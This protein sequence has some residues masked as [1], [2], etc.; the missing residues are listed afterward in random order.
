LILLVI[1]AGIDIDLST[2]KLIGTRG[3]LIAFFG[4]ILPIG[5]GM[6][7][8][9]ILGMT[10]IKEIIA[11]GAVFGPTS[12]G[13]A[14]NILRNGGILN[15]PVGQLIISAAVIDDMIALVVLSQLKALSGEITVAGILIPIVSAIAF[16]VFGGYIAVFILPPI[17]RNHILS[18]VDESNHARVE[19]GIMFFLVLALM[20][21]T[22]YAEASYL[23]G[24]F[25][26]GLTFCS[27]H[28]LHHAFVRQ[29][30]RVLQWLM[31]IFF[32]ASIGFQVPI[33]SFNDIEVIWQGL[34]YTLALIGKVAV[35][36]MVPNFSMDMRFTGK[37]LRDC[38]I[39]G[40]SM[41][42]EGEFAFVIAV[43]AVGDGLI[44][45]SLYAK[46]VLAV[47]LS[48][49][50]PPFL[51]RFTISYYNKKGEEAVE[52]AAKEE[53]NRRSIHKPN[54]ADIVHGVLQ[55]STIFLCIQTQSES[56]WGL[57][58]AIMGTMA[59][60]NLDV[61]DHRAWSPRGINTTLVN[62]IYARTMVSPHY[63]D[64]EDPSAAVEHATEVLMKDVDHALIRAINQPG[65]AKVKVQRWYPG[66]IQE[67]CEEV[68]E[69]SHKNVT[70]RL[71][72]EA[73]TKL[74][75]RQSLQTMATVQKSVAQILGEEE[76]PKPEIPSPETEPTPAV[77]KS[78]PRR[79]VRQKMRS[80]PVVGG[81]L[82]GET[83]EAKSGRDAST[84]LSDINK[85]SGG[86]ID[87]SFG[88]GKTG[89]PAEIT[90]KGEVYSIRIGQDTW[91][92]LQKGFHG[93]MVDN[94]GIE[95]A[96][97]NI[98]ASDDAPIVQRLQGFVRNMPLRSIS[99]EDS[100]LDSV[101]ERSL[102]NSRHGGELTGLSTT[103]S[104][105]TMEHNA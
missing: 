59:K 83:I 42:A 100:H 10:D 5:L 66:V 56:T 68:N 23:M 81:G 51:L 77:E 2:L 93:Q 33:Q 52:N 62:E 85:K 26:A 16:L 38:L 71:L 19:L 105:D 27:F 15:T 37:H 32:A 79:R 30:K 50:I 70:Q 58:N 41:A 84:R 24:C 21:A 40:F 80:T 49:I 64:D 88:G 36:F 22:Y 73:S 65:M 35:G 86:G 3:C 92:D 55:G 74:E 95:I 63:K 45:K 29:F 43:F 46:V 89:I 4:S 69:K 76:S 97:M 31:R 7:I 47:L 17:I 44:D 96:Q 94:R 14:L 54:D 25:V 67:I 53:D 101:S 90:V 78:R 39:T 102:E 11:A 13:I 99:E 20:P 82:F 57:L 104:I 6:L 28:E 72:K 34:V 12:L 60:H 9:W 103:D 87:W 48:T 18:R 8:T 61:I 91:K 75:Q 98:E 1:E